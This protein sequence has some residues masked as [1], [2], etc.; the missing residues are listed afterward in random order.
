MT[1]VRISPRAEQ[2]IESILAW[3]HA[4][5]GE[6]ARLRYEALVV[7]SIVDVARLSDSHAFLPRPELSPGA[8]TYHLRWSRSRVPQSK[9]RV[10]RPRHFLVCRFARDGTLEVAR[11]LHDSM[12]LDV[13]LPPDYRAADE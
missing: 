8:F 7:Q 13:H 6:S 5:F 2:D 9:G 11:V 12:D 4:Q 1:R 10:R 3:T